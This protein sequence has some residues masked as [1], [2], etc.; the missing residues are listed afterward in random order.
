MSGKLKWSDLLSMEM[1]AKK[2][3]KKFNSD[4]NSNRID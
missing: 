4:P 1:S 3:F 2:N